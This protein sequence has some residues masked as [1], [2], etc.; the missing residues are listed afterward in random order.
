MY[1]IADVSAGVHFRLPPCD[2]KNWGISNMCPGVRHFWGSGFVDPAVMLL[3]DPETSG[4]YHGIDTSAIQ[5]TPGDRDHGQQR[6]PSA[7]TKHNYI[8]TASSRAL[9]EDQLM[10]WVLNQS[11]CTLLVFGTEVQSSAA[12]W[13]SWVLTAECHGHGR[14]REH[15]Y[16]GHSRI[17][18]AAFHLTVFDFIEINFIYLSVCLKFKRFFFFF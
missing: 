12:G 16:N 5:F 17:S 14:Y 2:G 6:P 18:T 8:S 13:A 4:A 15:V 9:N 7:A 1:I 3:L 10:R 11:H